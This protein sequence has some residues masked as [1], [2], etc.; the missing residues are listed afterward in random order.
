[1]SALHIKGNEFKN[2]VLSCTDPVLVDFFAEWCGPCKRLAP[3]IE[4]IAQE[5]EG[6][7]KV[8]KVDVD[9]A[10]AVAAQYGIMSIPT[11]IL[12][13]DGNVS[14]KIVGLQSKEG[15]IKEFGL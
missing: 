13:K 6:K 11:L 10:N 7:I 12:F 2:E 9:E 4:E 5:Y 3:T 14:G 15:I 8:V 1:M